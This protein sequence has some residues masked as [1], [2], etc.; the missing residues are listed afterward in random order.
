MLILPI[1]ITV[2]SGHWQKI[3][4]KRLK[5]NF[6]DLQNGQITFRDHISGVCPFVNNADKHDSLHRIML[7]S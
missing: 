6:L 2:K 3:I 7:T 5:I 1:L 4:A